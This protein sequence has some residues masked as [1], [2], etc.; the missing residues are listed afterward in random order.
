MALLHP[1]AVIEEGSRKVVC[2]V[3]NPTPEQYLLFFSPDTHRSY[4][5]LA[6][7]LFFPYDTNG[8]HLCLYSNNNE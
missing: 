4:D 6:Y 3:Q 1:D 8:W 7:P 2:W 5:P